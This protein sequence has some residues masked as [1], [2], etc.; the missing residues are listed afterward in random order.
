MSGASIGAFPERLMPVS[1]RE[2][3]T[4]MADAPSFND[5]FE[6]LQRLNLSVYTPLAYVLPS[7][8]LKY[9]DRN[10]ITAGF[11]RGNLGQAP[12]S[13]QPSPEWSCLIRST[14]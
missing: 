6:Q 14:F 1:T 2:P 13:C 5:I 10:D 4:D 3:L 8:L 11:G 12:N 9:A 7:R